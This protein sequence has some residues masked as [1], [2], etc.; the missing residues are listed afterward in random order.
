MNE[1]RPVA[2]L[3]PSLLVRKGDARPAMRRPL[4]ASGPVPVLP[5]SVQGDAGRGDEEIDCGWNDMGA[6]APVLP[7][8]DDRETRD[9]LARAMVQIA[10]G[11]SG[12]NRGGGRAAFTLRLDTER[13]L[14][15]RLASALAGQSA[16]Y[17][18]TQALDAYLDGQPH[19][20]RLAHSA[21]SSDG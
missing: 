15:L 4:A 3:S 20:A 1:V 11:Q 16:Q 8:I 9:R 18:V 2:A 6:P 5:L 14:R 17:I 7:D 13:H 10:A 21:F 19:V 12:A